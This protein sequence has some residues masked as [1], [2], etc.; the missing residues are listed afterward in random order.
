MCDD[1]K[2]QTDSSAPSFELF[3]LRVTAHTWAATPKLMLVTST[4]E[5]QMSKPL[6][7]LRP[8]NIY[9]LRSKLIKSCL[10]KGQIFLT[11]SLITQYNEI[12][13]ALK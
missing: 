8:Q 10:S 12:P 7:K 3:C 11:P 6:G 4:S 1:Y 13:E 2:V 9:L 5:T